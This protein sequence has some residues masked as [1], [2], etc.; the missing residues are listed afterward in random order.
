MED[1]CED[2][3]LIAGDQLSLLRLEKIVGDF[4]KELDDSD[5]GFEFKGAL[6]V[7]S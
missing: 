3:Q 6:D 7:W 4:Q 2:L 5:C 1:F